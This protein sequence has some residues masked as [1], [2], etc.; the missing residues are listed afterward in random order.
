VQQ[1]K[2]RE[3]NQMND[4]ESIEQATDSALL[5]FWR[6]IVKA[7]PQSDSGNFTQCYEYNYKLL[8]GM[9]IFDLSNID[10]TLLKSQ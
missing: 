8:G 5:D 4:F 7:S 2:K 9:M 1:V 10:L 6:A 3:K